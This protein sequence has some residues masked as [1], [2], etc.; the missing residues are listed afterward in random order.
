MV[1]K[2]YLILCMLAILGNGCAS[3][4]KELKGKIIEAQYKPISGDA[5][6]V[7]G[8]RIKVDTPLRTRGKT[9]YFYAL[10]KGYG[11]F[12][13][14]EKYLFFDIF[15]NN[16]YTRYVRIPPESIHLVGET[17]SIY[18]P[19]E[20]I[21]PDNNISRHLLRNI[22][23]SN[24]SRIIYGIAAFIP[25]PDY[26]KQIKL[27]FQIEIDGYLD[28]HY[29]IFKR[30]DPDPDIVNRANSE[31]KCKFETDNYTKS[32]TFEDGYIKTEDLEII[33]KMEN[34]N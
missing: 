4:S 19:L 7:Q 11:I 5:Y 12:E 1:R 8:I 15:I 20:Y 25:P 21:Q 6:S 10:K 28:N 32:H 9:T 22:T 16:T 24:N 31:S 33:N 26:E 13:S 27:Q 14:T 34:L 23:E 3:R 17:Q 2:I 30:Q 18:N 29:V